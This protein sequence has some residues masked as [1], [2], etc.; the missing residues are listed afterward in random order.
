MNKILNKIIVLMGLVVLVVILVLAF[1][2]RDFIYSEQAVS[3]TD[4]VM[5]SFEKQGKLQV[6]E[7][8]FEQVHK[9]EVVRDLFGFD[10]LAP[11]SRT[12]VMFT[13][14][15]AA[16]VDLT[17]VQSEDISTVDNKIQIKLP[18]PELCE[19]PYILQ[20]SFMV[21][22]QNLVPMIMDPQQEVIAQKKAIPLAKEKALDN[23]ILDLAENQ[24]EK[25]IENFL[26]GI[27]DKEV[28]V[29]F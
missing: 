27:T 3:T 7:M 1:P 9:E 18:K 6:I 2:L 4:A 22:D 25:V 16:C 12:L 15:A 19:D 23:Q 28:E 10:W 17:Q 26:Y 8:Y 29:V 21:Y 20:D 11:D 13:S 14:V 24:A 5:K